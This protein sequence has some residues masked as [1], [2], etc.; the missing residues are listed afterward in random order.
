M[1]SGL[2]HRDAV[3]R[4]SFSGMQYE[5]TIKAG[6]SVENMQQCSRRGLDILTE[7]STKGTGLDI[8]QAERVA[9]SS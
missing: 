1:I 2:N 8:P 6:P 9:D 4:P 7:Y 5:H 3:H